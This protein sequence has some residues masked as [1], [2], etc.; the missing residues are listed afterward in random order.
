MSLQTPL[1]KVRGLGSAKE[2][3]GHFW[4]QRVTA[5]ANIPLV[6]FLVW[7]ILTTAGADHATV[8]ATL[9]EPFTGLALLLLVLSGTIHM[10]LGMQIIIEDYIRS[11]G[12]K[13]MALL[14]N[15]FFSILIAV[16]CIYAVMKL[17]LGA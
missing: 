6:L 8:R 15:T 17:A 1:N 5:V 13:L 10:R 3:T 7:T 14:L 2:G 9:S 4:M 12:L 16:A 11:E